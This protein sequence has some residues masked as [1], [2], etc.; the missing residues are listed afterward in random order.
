MKLKNSKYIVT[1]AKF[2]E[3]SKIFKFLSELNNKYDF[4]K[5]E[6]MKKNNF[7]F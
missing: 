5:I 2:V 3:S 1:L 6:I 7:F 4:I